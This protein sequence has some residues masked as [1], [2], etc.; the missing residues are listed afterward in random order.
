MVKKR[1]SR[2]LLLLITIAIVTLVLV[3]AIFKSEGVAQTESGAG[4]ATI[5]VS[6]ASVDLEIPPYK[7]GDTFNVQVRIKNYTHVAAWQVKVAYNKSMLNAS[8]CDLVAPS[9]FIFPPG[10]YTSVSAALGSGSVNG[11]H[12]YRMMSAATLGAVEY[13]KTVKPDAGLMN[14]TFTIM[15]VPPKGSTLSS[16]F[17][18]YAPEPPLLSGNGD[19]WTTDANVGDNALTTTGGSY[20]ISASVSDGGGNGGG[21]GSGG[22]FPFEIVAAV[23]IVVVAA[24][25]VGVLLLRR[26]KKSA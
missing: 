18:L 21:G 17:E 1:C 2:K 14:I 3:P 12:D 20:R 15:S 4:Y 24:A 16:F 7:L 5:Y 19:T 25:A 9:D 26:R 23:V 8:K 11:T 6:P 13:N 22:A 10:T